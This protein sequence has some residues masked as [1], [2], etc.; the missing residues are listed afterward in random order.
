MTN[1]KSRL[2][3]ILLGLLM[4]LG[5]SLPSFASAR[6]VEPSVG[7][8]VGQG[9][10][11]VNAFWTPQ[12]MRLAERYDPMRGWLKPGEPD[13]T[14]A[15]GQ[16][17]TPRHVAP[18]VRPP[19]V[20]RLFFTWLGRPASCSGS[21]IDTRSQRL[22][23]TAG[24]CVHYLGI[25]SERMIFVPAYQNGKRPYGSYRARTMWTTGP[26]VRVGWEYAMNYDMGMIVTKR[27]WNGQRIGDLVGSLPYQAFP[28]RYGRTQIL[29]YPGGGM[30][31]RR[32]RAC[33]T[34]TW[35]G[36]R[37]SGALFGP[38]GMAARCNMAAGSSGGPWMSVYSTGNGGTEL[39]VDGLTSMGRRGSNV[40]SSPYFGSHFR[41]LIYDADS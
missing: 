17:M 6:G 38:T 26:W 41:R 37:S 34:R 1:S 11:N 29:G 10:T 3:F 19:A 25:W 32:L 15:A 35:A 33:Y 40:L 24:H 9:S 28:R 20:G 14:G 18:L 30:K 12:K 4:L 5:L 31:S 8:R 23:L 16:R 13:A 27:T 2:H 7:H 21:V 36:P 39:V 22:V